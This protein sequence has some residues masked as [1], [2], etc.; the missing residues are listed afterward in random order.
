[1]IATTVMAIKATPKAL[2]LIETKKLE[3]DINKLT[4]IE[5]V[6]ETWKCYIPAAITGGMSVFCLIGSSSVNRRRN[7]AL[8]AV[9]AASETALKEYRDKV[10]ETFGDKKERGVRDAI[11]K[12]TVE[13]IPVTSKE[14]IVTKKGDTLCLDP[15]SRRY[16]KSDIEQ[17]KKAVNNVNKNMLDEMYVSLNDLYYE[18]GLENI[19]LGD[20][21][22]W[23]TNNLIEIGFSAQVADDGTPCIVLDFYNPPKYEYRDFY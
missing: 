16:F 2:R 15:L 1:M 14:V 10:V 13:R 21:I 7:A 4:F 11:A 17:I 5:T 8:A 9:Y 3:D 23:N 6:K 12:D 18:L 22:G 19:K 20:D